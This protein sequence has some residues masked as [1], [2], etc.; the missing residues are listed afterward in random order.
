LVAQKEIDLRLR[1]SRSASVQMGG[2]S[3]RTFWNCPA[4]CHPEIEKERV[5]LLLE[6]KKI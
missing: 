1:S 4:Q 5:S 2:T 6:G 3:P